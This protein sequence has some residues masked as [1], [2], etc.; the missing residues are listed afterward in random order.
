MIRL[1]STTF[2]VPIQSFDFIKR[3][4]LM[5]HH[6]QYEK[7]GNIH[8]HYDSGKLSHGIKNIRVK[9]YC[10]EVVI[11]LSAKVLGDNY[12]EGITKNNIGQVV[13]SINKTGLFSIKEN[14]FI[15]NGMIHKTDPSVT[16]EVEG[17]ISSVLNDL[18]VLGHN[19]LYD[20][21]PYGKDESIVFKRKLKSYHERQIMYSKKHELDTRRN[22]DFV[23]DHPT[24]YSSFTP[25][26]LRIEYGIKSH[27]RIRQHFRTPDKK[28][29]SILNSSANPNL[30]VYNRIACS[31]DQLEFFAD[32]KDLTFP[33]LALRVGYE[34]L[35]NW[36]DWNWSIIRREILSRQKNTRN[37]DSVKRIKRLF[38]TFQAERDRKVKDRKGRTRFDTVEM[39][40]R[41]LKD[42]V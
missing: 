21:T 33:K 12:R 40:R 9:E 24:A 6:G 14:T 41:L 3:S 17:Q 27:A 35:F 1:D 37:Y 29:M 19:P 39:I 38:N 32:N 7:G 22:R 16:I 15:D 36:A 26:S 4:D 42:A 25:N 11:D 28:I 8:T 18:Q 13:K 23:K 34:T 5:V 10:G 2:Q 31:I 30:M 20:L